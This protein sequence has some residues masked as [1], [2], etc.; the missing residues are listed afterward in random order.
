MSQQESQQAESLSTQAQITNVYNHIFA[1]LQQGKQ[2]GS[3]KEIS[4]ATRLSPQSLRTAIHSLCDTG[5]LRRWKSRP[6]E[7]FSPMHYEIPGEDFPQNDPQPKHDPALEG[8][9]LISEA[10]KYIRTLQ[11]QGFTIPEIANMVPDHID[12]SGWAE[13]SVTHVVNKTQPSYSGMLKTL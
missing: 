1:S 13:S 6:N 2:P 8:R 7:K 10:I 5:D 12:G 3:N 4:A 11:E 9:R